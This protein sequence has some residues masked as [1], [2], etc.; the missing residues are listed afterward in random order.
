MKKIPIGV[1]LY[2][3]REDCKKDLP[4]VLKAVARMGYE[5]VEFAGYHDFSASQLRKMLD[6]LNLKC[7][8][9]HTSIDTLS[10]GELQKTIDFHLTLGNK[11]LVVPWLPEEK[12]NSIAACKATA[13]EFNAIAEKVK[14]HGMYT[15]YHAHDCDCRPI[16][17]KTSAWEVL[18]DSTSKDVIMQLDTAN[19]TSGG[20]DPVA[21]LK[22]NPG[23]ARTLHLKE[24]SKNKAPIGE[25]T[26]KFPEVLAY[27]DQIGGTEWYIVEHEQYQT[28][29]LEGIDQC[30]KN[31]KK[32]IK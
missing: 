11:Y 8:G 17:G 13:N 19:A 14:K 23:R 26:V 29:P 7:C 16:E 6:D 28:T 31:L 10:G 20:A 12:R 30:L 22:R 15:G 32:M 3:V 21:L 25:G 1:Q 4:G 9:T 2:S 24:F 18:A 27:V 5:G